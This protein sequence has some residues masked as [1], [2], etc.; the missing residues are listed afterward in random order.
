MITKKNTL[1]DLSYYLSLPWTYTIEQA[2]EKGE[3]YYIIRVN[4]L[5]G[6]CTDA[7]TI[8]EAMELIKEVMLT[9][10]EFYVED[11][12][13]I[14]TPQPNH[15]KSKITYLTSKKREDFLRQEARRRNLSVDQIIDS[16]V[17]T[18]LQ[19]N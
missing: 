3:Y 4:E 2:C 11:G 16:L 18:A 6:A 7:P 5:P 14:P 15:H 17:D 9:F 19:K 10:F 13:P 8:P 12:E 1:K